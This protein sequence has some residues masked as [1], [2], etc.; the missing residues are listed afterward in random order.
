MYYVLIDRTWVDGDIVLTEDQM[1]D[2]DRNKNVIRPNEFN[3]LGPQQL[4]L[5]YAQYNWQ[6]GEVPYA[7]SGTASGKP[8][9]YNN[10]M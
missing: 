7:L 9:N 10:H 2:R 4:V 6:N 5:N 3:T 1:R 8:R